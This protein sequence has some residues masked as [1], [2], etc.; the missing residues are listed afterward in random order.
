MENDFIYAKPFRELSFYFLR[1]AG[2]R[3]IFGSRVADF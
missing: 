1:R 2:H 3:Y